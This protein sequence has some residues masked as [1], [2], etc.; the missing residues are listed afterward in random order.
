MD[1]DEKDGGDALRAEINLI[2][3]S[4]LERYPSFDPDR[5]Y[6]TPEEVMK[7]LEED[8]EIKTFMKMCQEHPPTGDGEGVGLLFPDS[9]YKPLT[10]ESPDKA[11]R[12]LYTAVKNLRCEDEVTIYILSPMLGIIPP[13][14]IPKTPNVE[15]SGLFSY[16]VRRRNLPW[17]AEAFRKVLDRTAESVE[18][19]LLSHSADHRWWYAIIKKGSIEERIFER[20]GFERKFGGRVL[21]EKRPLSGSYLETRRLIAQILEEMKR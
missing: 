17:N 20:V 18:S 7:A 11:L 5:I 8:G 12:N 1:M 10:E 6:L 19:Y 4:I 15:F 16:Q 9:N 21:Y 2:K 13:P 3:K 14:L